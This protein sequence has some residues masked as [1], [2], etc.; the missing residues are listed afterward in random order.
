[1]AGRFF[2]APLICAVALI[3]RLPFASFNPRWVV[4][5][6]LVV[7]GLGLSHPASP[8]YSNFNYGTG[9]PVRFS[10]IG[11]V[12]ERG[13]YYPATGLLRD[14]DDLSVPDS[15]LSGVG[16]ELRM[17]GLKVHESYAIGYEGYF[18]GP[19][20]HIIDINGLGDP[21]MARILPAASITEP[22]NYDGNYKARWIS[23]HL[24][25]TPPVGY[26][27]TITHDENMIRDLNL[28]AYYEKLTLITRG[29]LFDRDRWAAIWNMNIGAYDHLLDAYHESVRRQLEA[30]AEESAGPS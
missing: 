17:R 15:S 3:A 7:I 6:F 5:V 26:K 16:M 13:I 11:I 22:E 4:L 23:G 30:E 19:G 9:I 24:K 25:R 29:R 2:T 12:D 18:A 28:A 10:Q 21:L 20:V 27:N 8:I 1:M 14:R